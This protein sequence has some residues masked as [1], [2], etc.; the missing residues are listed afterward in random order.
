[1]AAESGVGTRHSSTV[2]LN[3]ALPRTLDPPSR[4]SGQGWHAWVIDHR[5]TFLYG[6]REK[7][8]PLLKRT[9]MNATRWL[10]A[11]SDLTVV[12]LAM[13]GLGAT[14]RANAQDESTA[15]QPNFLLSVAFKTNNP[16]GNSPPMSGPEARQ[17]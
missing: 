12:V 1:V 10:Q 15:A 8:F 3:A 17:H 7:L 13:A 6:C 4:C 5:R 14:Q 16:D 2:V 9:S 11:C